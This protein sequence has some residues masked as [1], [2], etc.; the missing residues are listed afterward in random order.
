[1]RNMLAP[2]AFVYHIGNATTT[3]EGLLRAEHTSVLEHDAIID[4]RYPNYRR[5]LQNFA[6]RGIL[7]QLQD[8]GAQ[9]LVL[10]GAREHGYVVEGSLIDYAGDRSTTGAQFVVAPDGRSGSL[11]GSCA[12]FE[13]SYALNGR[14]VLELLEELVGKPPQSVII[15]DRGPGAEALA[16]SAVEQSVPVIDCYDYPRTVAPRGRAELSRD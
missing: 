15:R 3:S 5:S 14:G 10:A 16:R 12:G 11:Q 8:E 13:A 2:S 1:M 9:V 7:Q 4:L 6:D